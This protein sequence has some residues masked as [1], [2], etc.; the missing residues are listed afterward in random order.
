MGLPKFALE[1]HQF[2]TIIISIL[3]L[4]GIVSFLTMPRSEDPQIS[5]D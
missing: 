1:N 4:M 5:P 2:S 3:V